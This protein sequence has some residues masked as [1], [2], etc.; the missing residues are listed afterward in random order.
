MGLGWVLNL[1][2]SPPVSGGGG[3]CVSL[4][5]CKINLSGNCRANFSRRPFHEW[6]W[7]SRQSRNTNE[8]LVK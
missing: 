8:F 6:G 5:H 7:P 4:F 1:R 3:V 2:L